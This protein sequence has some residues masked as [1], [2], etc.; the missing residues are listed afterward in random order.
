MTE[1]PERGV[2]WGPRTSPGL[3]GS[4]ERDRLERKIGGSQQ[5]NKKKGSRIWFHLGF[6]EGAGD[7]R[8]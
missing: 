5:I 8:N 7:L 4:R 3:E 2:Y 1:K 6:V